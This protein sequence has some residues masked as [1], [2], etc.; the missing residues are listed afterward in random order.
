MNDQL[1]P[2]R[3]VTKGPAEAGNLVPLMTA[4]EALADIADS[5][6]GTSESLSQGSPAVSWLFESAQSGSLVAIIRPI[7][8]N[9]N[10]S[11]VAE[12]TV[13]RLSTAIEAA[14]NGMDVSLLLPPRASAGIRRL[15]RRIEIGELASTTIERGNLS[16]Q[17]DSSSIVAT[18]TPS[19]IDT[20]GSVEGALIGV[21][22]GVS[23][24]MTV[25]S[26]ISGSEV[27]CHFSIDAIDEQS[28]RDSLR[29]RVIVA[30]VVSTSPDGST[31]SLSKCDM[32]RVFPNDETLPTADDLA[33][34]APD[35]ANGQ[36]AETWVGLSRA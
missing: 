6:E 5:L 12:A 2:L 31:R 23:P 13:H 26:A 22:F 10:G 35:F 20:Y 30:G 36:P 29:H 4:A 7:A 33:G 17:I 19:A 18:A 9:S 27:N 16:V 8:L 11:M 28:I 1:E 3:I 15:L 14:K 34:I 24:F 21:K 32:L 25:R